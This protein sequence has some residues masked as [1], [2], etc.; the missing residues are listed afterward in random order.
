MKW[1]L[2]SFEFISRVTMFRGDLSLESFI[3]KLRLEILS[4]QQKSASI[5]QVF[6]EWV[7]SCFSKFLS[8]MSNVSLIM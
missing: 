2:F 6:D 5:G 3:S 1:A 4:R 7:K 8:V